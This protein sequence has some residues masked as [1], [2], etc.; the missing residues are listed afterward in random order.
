MQANHLLK[1]GNLSVTRPRVEVINILNQK[2]GPFSAEELLDKLPPNT[3]DQATVYR[4]LKL[5]TTKGILKQVSSKDKIA[6]YE[7]ATGHHH[8][9]ITCNNCQKVEVIDDCLVGTLTKG[10]QQ[11]GYSQITHDLE[12]YGLCQS[13]QE[14]QND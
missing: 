13:C 9:H 5:L 14:K 1:N 2:H 12:F 6:R 11:R 7:L 4:T 8:H 10:L 3:C